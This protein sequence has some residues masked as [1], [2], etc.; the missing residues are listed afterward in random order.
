MVEVVMFT[1]AALSSA[2][3]SAKLSGAPL[4]KAGKVPVR[5]TGAA[6]ANASA[7]ARIRRGAAGGAVR[8]GA[9]AGIGV[10]ML[11]IN[12]RPP[13]SSRAPDYCGNGPNTFLKWRNLRLQRK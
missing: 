8:T 6:S 7:K 12:F 11:D 3:R 4:A 5:P 10:S 9:R 13:G 2:E 1:T